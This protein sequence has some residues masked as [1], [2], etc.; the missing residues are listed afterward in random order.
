MAQNLTDYQLKYNDLTLG[1][2]TRYGIKSV[3]GLF[4]IDVDSGSVPIPRGDG[5][6]PGEDFLTAKNIEIELIV[7][8]EKQ[9]QTMADRINNVRLAFQRQDKPIELYFKKPGEPEQFVLARPTGR[10]IQEDT[11]SEHGIKPITI[12]L[13]AADPRLY[14]TDSHSLSM[15]VH[16]ID[17]GGTEFS[18]EFDAEFTATNT[19]NVVR[20][21]GN[22]KAYPILSFG[23]P[24]D[25]GTIDAVKII[26]ETTGQEIEITATILD[27][28]TLKADML[29]YIRADGNQV[30]GLDGASRYAD[31]VLPRE[32]FY[33]QPGDN[34][35]RYEISAGTSTES[36]VTITW[37]DTSI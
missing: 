16:E 20:N 7:E 18:M 1:R 9:S 37:F 10:A 6:I 2:N 13:H 35:L 8:A 19:T 22:A 32:P 4:D 11:Q 21:E 29:S 33:L 25:A 5:N 28:Q 26:N 14:S 23:G 30:I 15:G 31:W 36:T 17:S 3:H 27:G 24:E 34:I 12:R